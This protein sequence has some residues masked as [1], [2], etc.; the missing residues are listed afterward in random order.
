MTLEKEV[1]EMTEK[2]F[3]SL[4]YTPLVASMIL[5]I[6]ER[7]IIKMFGDKGRLTYYHMIDLGQKRGM[8]PEQVREKILKVCHYK[9]IPE[10]DQVQ[11]VQGKLF[12]DL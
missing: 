11:Y 4:D 5:P 8:L 9:I 7:N 10:T 6:T 3:R 1:F 2:E 12:D